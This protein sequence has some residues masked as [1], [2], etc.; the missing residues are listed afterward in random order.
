MR[1]FSVCI[2]GGGSTFTLGFLKSFVRMREQF[3]LKKLVLFDI[4]KERQ[5]IIGKFGEILFNEKFP[6]LEFVYTTDVKEAYEG[7][8]FVFMQM[9]AGGLPMRAKDEH[10]PLSMGMVGQETCGAGGMAYG[11]RSVVDMIKAVH[12]I[13]EFAP[14]AWILNYS[15]PAAI[16]AEAL[17]REFPEDKR[18]LNICDQPENVV[19]SCSRLLGVDWETLDPVYFG[20]NH[21][22]WFTHIYDI[23]TG[24]DLLPKIKD[25]ISKNGFLPQDAEQRDPSWLD[26]YGMVETLMKDYPEFLPNTYNQYYLYPE[27]KAS[28]LN[29][30]FTRADEVMAG[31]EKRVFTECKEVIAAG[32]LGDKFDDISDAHAEMMINVAEAIAYNK[33]NRHILIVENNGAIN[34]MQDDAM[35]EVVCELGANGP[36]PMR[37]GN[38]PQFNLGLLVNQVSCEKLIVDAYFEKSYQ[39]A[40]EAFTLNRMI[41]DGKKARKILDALIE[42]NKGMWP[43][44]K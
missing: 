30:D 12:D 3:P 9:R 39:K 34:N 36:R 22:G 11:L 15:N 2:V 18:I 35:V 16:V 31:R 13:R 42:A 37:I 27:Y 4:D 20:L 26:T 25:L 10:I 29:P 41:N 38:I 6:E 33:N 32:T 5:D 23:N 43:D 21:Y 19:R 28:H 14:A 40:L 44:L 7:M 17:R 24:E 1:K 8:D